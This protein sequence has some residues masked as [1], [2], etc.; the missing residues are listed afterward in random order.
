M[1]HVDP[2]KCLRCGNPLDM[3]FPDL[4]ETGICADC[5][6]PGDYEPG[7]RP[8]LTTESEEK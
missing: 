1:I 3:T 4:A 2:D 8:D 7:E 6:E 5:W